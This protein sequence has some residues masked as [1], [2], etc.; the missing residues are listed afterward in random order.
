[1]QTVVAGARKKK[2]YNEQLRETK[3]FL[4]SSAP[5]PSKPEHA[6]PAETM[7]VDVMESRCR[8]GQLHDHNP[9]KPERLSGEPQSR[10]VPACLIP[11]GRGL[12]KQGTGA[13][14]SG[15]ECNYVLSLD[16]T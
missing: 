1:M 14:T 6:R 9:E 8:N 16:V 12:G 11:N 2:E 15:H 5:M 4:R 13:H 3:K 10:D 7:D